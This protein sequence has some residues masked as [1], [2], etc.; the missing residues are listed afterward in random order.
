MKQGI[1]NI[2][3]AWRKGQGSRRTIIGVIKRNSTEGVR[4]RYDT[5]AVEAANKDG[6][7]VYTDFPDVNKEYTENVLDIFSQRLN[8]SERGD[9]QKYYD[10][11]EIDPNN[12]DDKYYLLAHTQGLLAT[13]NF[14]FLA[15]YSP[16]PDLR[17]VSEL[18]GLSTLQLPSDTLTEGEDLRWKKEPNNEHDH[19][20][21]KVYKG[22]KFV[23]YVKKI[24]S[25]VFYKNGSQ[26]LKIKVKSITKNG[27]IN[28]V[29]LKIYSVSD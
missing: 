17:F 24:H 4:F 7:S 27:H 14:E 9:I 13:D 8:K 10:F 16:V 26:Q 29:F 5:K 3:L 6:L 2:F 12:K 11:W 19:R 18:C 23:G 1:G 22:N 21:V 20:A 28:R 15:D 25:K